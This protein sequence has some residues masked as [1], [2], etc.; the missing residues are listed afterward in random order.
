MATYEGLPVLPPL[1]RTLSRMLPRRSSNL[2]MKVEQPTNQDIDHII[3]YI[4]LNVHYSRQADIFV[5]LSRILGQEE[6]CL[7]W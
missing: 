1:V 7:L 3:S 4:Y 5:P 2:S 6:E